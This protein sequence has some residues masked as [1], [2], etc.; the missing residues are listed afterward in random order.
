MD[1]CL[2]VFLDAFSQT[3]TVSLWIMPAHPLQVETILS[4]MATNGND[5]NQKPQGCHVQ[6]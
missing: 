4:E 5:V 2:V 6:Q 3:D 1:F